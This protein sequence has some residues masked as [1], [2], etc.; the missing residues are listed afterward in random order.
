MGYGALKALSDEH[1]EVKAMRTS[2][3]YLRCGVA[4]KILAAILAELRIPASR[5]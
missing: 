2:R 1:G 5:F 4:T 3:E